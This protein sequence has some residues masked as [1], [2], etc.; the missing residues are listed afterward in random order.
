VT[1]RTKICWLIVGYLVAEVNVASL[2][3]DIDAGKSEFQS[4]CASCH[5]IDGKGSGP[6]SAQLKVPAPD[7]TILARRN[8]GALPLN[9]IYEMIDGR[10]MVAAHGVREMPIW[11]KQYMEEASVEPNPVDKLDFPIEPED[12]V[13]TRIL[14]LIDYILRIQ[15]K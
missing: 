8:N 13:R 4:S 11:G 9:A 12:I 6:L 10:K 3:Q 14:S 2:A 7:L 15:E 5:G 1:F